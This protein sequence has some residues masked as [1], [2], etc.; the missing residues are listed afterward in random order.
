M[1]WKTVYIY[2]V[3]SVALDLETY[4]NTMCYVEREY[5]L[6]YTEYVLIIVGE[7]GQ[8]VEAT[9]SAK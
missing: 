5:V 3:R 1:L 6:E 2:I 7:L 9:V 8:H 4:H